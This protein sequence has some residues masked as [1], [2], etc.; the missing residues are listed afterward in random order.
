MKFCNILSMFAL[1]GVN[2]AYYPPAPYGTQLQGVSKTCSID[3]GFITN[4]VDSGSID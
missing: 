3:I 4:I 2:S 1:F